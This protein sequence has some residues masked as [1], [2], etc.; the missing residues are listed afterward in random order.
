MGDTA[1][2]RQLWKEAHKLVNS[3]LTLEL[4]LSGYDPERSRK[5]F[6]NRTVA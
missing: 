4:P 2:R 3:G 5:D 6:E 1:E